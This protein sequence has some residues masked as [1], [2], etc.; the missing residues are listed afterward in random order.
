MCMSVCVCA[1]NM[2][3]GGG[4]GGW[5]FFVCV[6]VWV[7]VCVVKCSVV[8][9]FQSQAVAS[10]VFCLQVFNHFNQRCNLSQHV[11]SHLY[12]I[13]TPTPKKSKERK[14]DILVQQ[15]QQG[16]PVKANLEELVFVPP[17]L[18]EVFG[19][20]CV[21][22]VGMCGV[23]VR[24][25]VGQSQGA[26]PLQ[27]CLS[28]TKQPNTLKRQHTTK[29]CMAKTTFCFKSMKKANQ[30]PQNH[31]STNTHMPINQPPTETHPFHIIQSTNQPTNKASKQV[32]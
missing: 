27:Q 31:S 28:H 5:A 7:H 2:Y 17:E 25:A 1:C 6:C 19:F 26:I 32:N 21:V 30:L 3:V 10:M 22:G 9:L 14:N 8:L 16:Q 29:R 23:A 18:V 20:V 11:Y 4:G 12:N 24:G 13:P 15:C